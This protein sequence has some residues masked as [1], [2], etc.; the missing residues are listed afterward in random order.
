M[1]HFSGRVPCSE[2]HTHTHLAIGERCQSTD[3]TAHPHAHTPS[4][5]T[6][7]ERERLGDHRL[8]ELHRPL[9]QRI[10][11]PRPL[12]LHLPLPPDLVEL[13]RGGG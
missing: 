12:P 7:R 4:A 9:G 1:S 6:A 10:R 13:E 11:P 5:T 8:R 2:P 3:D